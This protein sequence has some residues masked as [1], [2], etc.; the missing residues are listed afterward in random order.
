MNIY[1]NISI[2]NPSHNILEVYNI[3]A[4]L[5]F[6]TSKMKLDILNNLKLKVLGN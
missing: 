1:Y 5:R 2:C 6:A 3:L 4:Q